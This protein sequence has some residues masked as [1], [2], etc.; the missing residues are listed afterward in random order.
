MNFPDEWSENDMYPDELFYSQ[1]SAYRPGA[2]ER[3]EHFRN[4]A[5]HWWLRHDS[6]KERLAILLRLA[7]IDPDS[8]VGQDIRKY[9]HTMPG[10]DQQLS[11]LDRE[12][13]SS[14]H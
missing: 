3:S 8:L 1:L 11:E 13:F 4:G 5:F 7:A 12:L 2:E 10:F 14:R 9:I 6:R